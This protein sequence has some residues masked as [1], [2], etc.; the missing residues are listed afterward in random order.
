VVATGVPPAC[1]GTAYLIFAVG[2][3]NDHEAFKLTGLAVEHR[4]WQGGRSCRSPKLLYCFLNGLRWGRHQDIPAASDWSFEK[5]VVLAGA[6]LSP[7]PET[8]RRLIRTAAVDL[9]SGQM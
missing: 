7:P 8:S 3:P 6:G 4:N 9:P 1:D 5:V 2:N